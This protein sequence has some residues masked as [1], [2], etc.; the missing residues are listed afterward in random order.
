VI[1]KY[2]KKKKSFFRYILH[3][4]WYICPIALPVRRNTQRRNLL[5]VVSA[6]F[7]PPFQPFR[8]Q[9][10]V[11]HQ[12]L[13]R[14]TLETLPAINRKHVFMNTIC[15]ESFS[16]QKTH[17]R[18]LLFGSILL[19]HG[20]RCD[21]WNKPLNM[22]MR[23]CYLDSKEAGLCC[24]LVMQMENLLRP[25][26]LL[27][28]HCWRIYWPSHLYK[29]MMR[30]MY[31]FFNLWEITEGKIPYRNTSRGTSKLLWKIFR[32]LSNNYQ[33][34]SRNLIAYNSYLWKSCPNSLQMWE[35]EVD[36]R[37]V[38]LLWSYSE[39]K[40]RRKW[41]TKRSTARN[42]ENSISLFYIVNF[43]QENNI[44]MYFKNILSRD[45]SVGIKTG[46]ENRGSIPGI[47]KRFFFSFPQCPDQIWS[48]PDLLSNGYRVIFP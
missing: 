15:C 30:M 32:V 12:G 11:F 27:Y 38:R 47:R 21:Y 9:R 4:H 18:T 44:K 3:Q 13:N 35:L 34:C 37:T 45:S 24:C 26:Q 29:K 14:F 8:Q 36:V 22:R 46:V 48:S 19:K 1:F 39:R 5:T 6:T 41:S 2:G 40:T 16:P 28:F 43:T 20:R 31:P 17:K 33:L 25:L 42:L 7:A 23:V 10:N